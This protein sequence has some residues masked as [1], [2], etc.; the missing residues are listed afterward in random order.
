MNQ[1]MKIFSILLFIL[2]AASLNISAQ[3][4]ATN[5]I[6]SH[7]EQQLHEASLLMDE[8]PPQPGV[9]S[10]ERKTALYLTD[11][12]LH[13]PL[14]TRKTSVGT[15]LNERIGRVLADLSAPLTSGMT[16]YKIYNCGTI[17]KTPEITVAFD[18]NRCNKVGSNSAGTGVITLANMRKLVDECDI[19]FISHSHEDHVDNAFIR[20]FI[21]H[22]KPVIAPDDAATDIEG[23]THVSPGLMQQQNFTAAGKTLATTIIPAHQSITGGYLKNNIYIVTTPD[24][25]RIC[26]TGDLDSNGGEASLNE[27]GMSDADYLSAVRN[28]IQPVDLLLPICWAGRPGLFFV[29]DVFRPSL[30]ITY[31]ENEL[32]HGVQ[33]RESLTLTEMNTAALT[34]PYVIM[35]WGEWYHYEK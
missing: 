8:F 25:Y 11:A 7:C 1:S 26:A 16:V 29:T 31:H 4:A 13:N 33:S 15:F 6:H 30:C 24:N 27:S 5:T 35:N 20:E 14:L 12:V 19:L 23:V 34:V 17:I 32:G 22:G 18:L 3:N 9:L 2:S 28:Q 10:A 21:K